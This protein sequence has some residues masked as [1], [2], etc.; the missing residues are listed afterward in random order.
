MKKTIFITIGTLILLIVVGVW[1]YLFLYGAPKNSGEVFTNFGLGGNTNVSNINPDSTVDI[2]TT[3][4]N[5]ARQ[6]LKQLTTRP[7]AGATFIVGG[8]RYVE[9]GTGHVYDIDLTSGAE[10]LM[11][12]TTL[13]QTADAVFVKDGSYVAI[14]AYTPSG[15]KTILQKL[16]KDQGG[17]IPA[18]V[19]LP[20][21]A[22]EIYFGDSTSTLMYL[23]E[24]ST[25]SSGYS[26]NLK[27]GT[28][29]QVFKIA[30]RD[31]HVLWGSTNYAYT[32]P[33]SLSTGQPYRVS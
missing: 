26:Y 12:G 16:E 14:T 25:G 10:S 18:G 21:G 8:I 31:I 5:G 30:L 28:G 17:N 4:S 29:T 23:L 2:Q 22:R 24:E 3:T 7:V 1:G 6:K 33:T 20:L 13:P 9:Q 11:N 32:T 27:K 19:A 15:N